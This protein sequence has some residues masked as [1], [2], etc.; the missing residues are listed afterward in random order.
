MEKE[1]FAVVVVVVAFS[2]D[3]ISICLGTLRGWTYLM[4]QQ[5]QFAIRETFIV[6]R[7]ERTNKCI[8]LQLVAIRIKHTHT[9]ND[10]DYIY[11]FKSPTSYW[12][13]IG[14]WCLSLYQQ[15]S[16]SIWKWRGW[17]WESMKW[18]FNQLNGL[19]LCVTNQHNKPPHMIVQSLN[20][21]PQTI[22]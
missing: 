18:L 15:K 4:E 19:S 16:V 11:E 14:F 17:I 1:C 5:N 9:G 2:C 3:S 7:T 13:W 6:K 20:P 21:W 12:S 8:F 22:N 10:D